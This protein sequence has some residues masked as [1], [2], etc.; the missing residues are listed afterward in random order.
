MAGAVIPISPA[1]LFDFSNL[2]GLSGK[3]E[4]TL[5]QGVVT[6]PWLQMQLMVR[7]TG[8]NLAGGT[9][10]FKVYAEG[11]TTDD[12]GQAFMF[13]LNSVTLSNSTTAPAFLSTGMVVGGI[14][15]QALR[16]T[17]LATRTAALPN[18]IQ[19]TCDVN[20]CLKNDV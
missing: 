4:L 19:A 15:G 12:P 9:L 7:V 3:F 13:P 16:V 5:K 18:K 20:L 6:A 2:A 17:V 1:R 8:V 14:I 11:P 10:E